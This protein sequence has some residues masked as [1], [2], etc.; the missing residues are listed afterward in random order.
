MFRFYSRFDH[1]VNNN[2]PETESDEDALKYH[3]KVIQLVRV[4]LQN[5]IDNYDKKF[6]K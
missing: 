5:A 2:G 3:I 1:I 6:I 4:D